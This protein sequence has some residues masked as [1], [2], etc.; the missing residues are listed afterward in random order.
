MACMVSHQPN[1][2]DS[3]QRV[4]VARFCYLPKMGIK[5]PEMGNIVATKNT[6]PARRKAVVAHDGTSISLADALF[7]TTQQRVLGLL[8]GQTNR[9]FYASEIIERT[10]S[11]SGAVQRE[12]KRLASSGLVTVKRI[13]NQ[14]HYH[15]NP[16]APVFEELRGLVKKTVALAEPIREALGSLAD[17]VRLALLF[18]SVAKG[19]DTAKSDIDILVVGDGITLEDVFSALIP[20]EAELNRKISP[21]LYTPEEFA[22]RKAAN[23]PFITRVLAGEHLVLIGNEHEKF[24]TR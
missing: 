5:M 16:D 15:A 12:L 4:P 19:T 8:F 11:G 14:R 17:R 3:D 7:T 22:Q 10:G 21:T 23:N 13:G 1:N 20:V 18:G 9:S 24:A 2:S 6:R